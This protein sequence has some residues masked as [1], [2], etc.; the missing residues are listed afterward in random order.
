MEDYEIREG[1]QRSTHP[2]VS[3][4]INFFEGPDFYRFEVLFKNM[5]SKIAHQYALSIRA[6]NGMS[7]GQYVW[8]PDQTTASTR[9][10]NCWEI[11]IPNGL[12]QRPL[13]PGQELTNEYD[14]KCGI[15]PQ[16]DAKEQYVT[17]IL[18][19]DEMPAKKYTISV[20]EFFYRREVELM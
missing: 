19:A 14:I 16:E 6:P 9:Y 7:R 15:I 13:F 20:D 11:I 18:Y 5:G 1:M 12:K 2:Q 17:F 3:A 4:K 10:F 8:Y